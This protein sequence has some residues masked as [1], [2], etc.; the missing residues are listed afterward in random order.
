MSFHYESVE[1]SVLAPLVIDNQIDAAAKLSA[2]LQLGGLCVPPYWVKKASREVANTSVQLSTVL[3]YPLGYQRTEAKVAEMELAFADGAK[4]VELVINMSAFKSQRMNWIKAE[5]A[6]FANMIHAREALLTVVA[7]MEYL[8][9]KEIETCCK[10]SA[11]AGA[12]YIKPLTGFLGKATPVEQVKQLKQLLPDSVGI[13]AHLTGGSR[14]RVEALLEAGA[15][16]V[17][18]NSVEFL[19][20][21]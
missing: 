1:Y 3:G 16:K 14:Q 20:T 9:E 11:D 12:D 6:K 13:K 5:I 17:S 18:V 4:A 10:L 19:Q 7:E 8:N 2:S 21:N 15:Q